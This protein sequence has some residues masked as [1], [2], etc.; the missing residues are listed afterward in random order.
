M[1]GK[2]WDAV[3]F[4]HRE[5]MGSFDTRGNMVI[6][7]VFTDFNR[8]KLIQ[9]CTGKIEVI[10]QSSEEVENISKKR[11]FNP[12]STISMERNSIILEKGE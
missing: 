6:L 10:V 1:V 2:S 4:S 5:G 12:L 11:S 7:D 8:R 9:I 3:H